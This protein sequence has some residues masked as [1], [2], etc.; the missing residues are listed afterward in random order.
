MTFK[1][2]IPSIKYGEVISQNY[3]C[4]GK[5]MSP[6]LQ[7][8][9]APQSA[10]SFILI[11]EDPDA[12][13][14]TFVHWILYN[15]KPDVKSLPENVSKELTTPEGWAQ[16]KNDFGK[17]GYGGPCPPG[18]QVHRYFFY[19]YGV[20]QAPDLQA[21]MARKD[22]ERLLE[23]KTVKRASFMVKYGRAYEHA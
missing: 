7:W 3:T 15:I 1:L 11:M 23:N 21:G 18:K 9:D 6:A 4:D 13:R 22:L 2:E 5:D 8:D 14:G 19:L 16:G 10:K 17:I 12:P 20:L